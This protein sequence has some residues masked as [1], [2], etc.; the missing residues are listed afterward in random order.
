MKFLTINFFLKMRKIC[1]EKQ[2]LCGA[3]GEEGVAWME[4]V[5]LLPPEIP[6]PLHRSSSSTRSP[7]STTD[8]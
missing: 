5:V 1:A 8:S 2:L 4:K 3:D 6:P 7:T